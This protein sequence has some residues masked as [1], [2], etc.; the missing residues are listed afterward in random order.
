MSTAPQT[1]LPGNG[2]PGHVPSVTATPLTGR[3]C[4]T[5]PLV[6]AAIAGSIFA[7]VS[8]ALITVEV[9]HELVWVM[10]LRLAPSNLRLLNTLWT[11]PMLVAPYPRL[12]P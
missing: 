7:L 12:L 6:L 2:Y 5:S 11:L 8:F 1:A 10:V 9:P 3:R 4:P